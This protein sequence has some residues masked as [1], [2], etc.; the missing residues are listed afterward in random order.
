VALALSKRIAA[1]AKVDYVN[2]R[3]GAHLGHR[4][5]WSCA[6]RLQRW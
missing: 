6:R 5:A 3:K 4:T 2:S 1:L